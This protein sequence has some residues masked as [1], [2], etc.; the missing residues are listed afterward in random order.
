MTVFK[1][2]GLIGLN[3]AFSGT[4]ENYHTRR[5]SPEN[6]SLA[7]LQHLGANALA[8]TRHFGTATVEPARAAD[9]IYFDWL[10]SR[11]IHYPP[12]VVWIVLTAAIALLIALFLLWRRSE[13]ITFARV[14]AGL[15]GFILL[16][17]ASAAGAHLA[18]WLIRLAIGSRLLFGDTPS[19]MLLVLGCVA[20]AFAFCAVTQTWL[21]AR[22]GIDHV[23]FGQML[24]FTIITIAVTAVSPTASYVFQWPLVFALAGLLVAGR[25]STSAACSALAALPAILVFAPLTYLLFVVLGMN[26]IT[27]YVIATLLG[28]FLA[29]TAPLLV[30]ISRPLEVCLPATIV[31]A[32][33]LLLI[34]RHHSRFSPEH[35][36]RN[37]LIYSINAD[38]QKA[39]WISYDDAVDEW[40]EQFLGAGAATSESR[41]IHGG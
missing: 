10:G 4:F 13:R 3:F 22:V 19:N 35:P 37:T 32:I 41:E 26:S 21:I 15:G 8:L 16:L 34:G 7:S 25:A 6:L 33:A 11:M 28:I 27:I 20:S 30:Q 39:A 40:T 12:W 17:L 1:R 14:A 23:I 31:A 38:E 5:D 24:G 9:R 18:W 2:A 29:V 36:R